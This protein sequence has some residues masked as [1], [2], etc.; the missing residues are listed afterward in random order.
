M[1]ISIGCDH[2]GFDVAK[3][4]ISFLND[5]GYEVDNQGCHSSESVDYPIFGKKVAQSILE[6]KVDRGIIICGTGIGISI[7]ANREPS[8]RA[9]L[10]HDELTAMMARAH[11]DANVMAIGARVTNQEIARNCLKT[12]F[13]TSFEGGRHIKR[14]AKLTSSN[15]ISGNNK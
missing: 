6:G 1:K 3:T 10:V 12:F 8:V 13:S 9:A 15:S 7:A 11:N 2:A 4:I 14:V 5:S